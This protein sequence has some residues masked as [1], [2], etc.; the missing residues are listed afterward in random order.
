MVAEL[1]TNTHPSTL[2]SPGRPPLFRSH[3]NCSYVSS[4]PFQSLVR[5]NLLR[6]GIFDISTCTGYGLSFQILYTTS[7]TYSKI[8]IY[9]RILMVRAGSINTKRPSF[10][11][12]SSVL[13]W[14]KCLDY[15]GLR[16]NS[17]INLFP[18]LSRHAMLLVLYSSN[19]TY[20]T[21]YRVDPSASAYL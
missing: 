19:S 13:E 6:I 16:G 3:P 1:L 15:P 18:K 10:L 9:L 12:L 4:I 8:S 5:P 7:T 21:L 11:D 17:S 14:L 20:S 2:L